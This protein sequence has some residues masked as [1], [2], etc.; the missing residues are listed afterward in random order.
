MQTKIKKLITATAALFLLLS[1]FAPA[2]TFAM[3]L[4]T[5]PTSN[6]ATLFFQDDSH[7]E[8]EDTHSEEGDHGAEDSHSEET[9]SVSEGSAESAGAAIT[10]TLIAGVLIIIFVVAVIGAVGLGIIGVGYAFINGGGE[11]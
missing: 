2:L 7:D 8:E 6:G 10:L 1:L 9:S 11:E 4:G 3:G 5:E